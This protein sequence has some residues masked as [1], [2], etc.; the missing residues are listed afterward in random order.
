MRRALGIAFLRAINVGGHVVKMDRLRAIFTEEGFSNVETFIASGNV[1]FD[2]APRKATTPLEQ[3]IEAMLR[4]ALG[5]EVATFIRTGAELRAVAEHQPFTA[6][7]LKKSVAFNV[8]FLRQAPDAK[9]AAAIKAL[10][11]VADDFHLRGRDLYWLSTVRQGESKISN[12]VFEKTLG[13]PSTMRGIA[14]IRKMA[15]KY[16][17]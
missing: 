1:V 12:A 8:A 7:A 3:S 13:H 6:A 15:E 5:Y 14:T 4:K 16:G 11:T 2:L 17:S 9:A 10:K